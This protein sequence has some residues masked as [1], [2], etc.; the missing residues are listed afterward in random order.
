MKPSSAPDRF[1]LPFLLLPALLLGSLTPAAPAPAAAPAA[2]RPPNLVFIMADDLG[3]GDLPSYRPEAPHRT[4]HLDRLAAQGARFTDFYVTSPVCT[5]SRIAFLTGRHPARYRAFGVIWP[6]TPEG[7][8][9]ATPILSEWLRHHGYITGIVG[10]WHVG[11]LYPEQLPPARG[12]DSWYGMPYPNDMAP[13]HPQ[14]IQRK[15]TWPQMPMYRDFA[16]V[17]RPIDPNLLT[18]QYTYEALRFIAENHH[19]PFF[20]FLSH[21]MPHSILGASPDFYGRS[22]NGV[23]GDGVEELDW[24]V[25]QVLDALRAFSLEA[26]TLVFFTSDNGA[27]LKGNPFPESGRPWGLGSNLPLRGGKTEVFEGGIRLPAIASWPGVIPPGS[28]LSTPATIL[29]LIPTWADLASLPPMPTAVDGVSLAPILRQPAATLPERSLFFGSGMVNA[30]R[31][32]PWKFLRSPRPS[33][34]PDATEEP[35]LFNLANDPGETTNLTTSHPDILAALRAEADR[36]QAIADADF[37]SRA[38]AP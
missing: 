22:A 20:L 32:G 30:V 15:E 13:G 37:A 14:E 11:H 6:T 5:P 12:F 1:A 36:F 21:A 26:N 2:S 35:L 27:Y 31:R 38:P 33:Y 10:K 4:P 23:Y 18:R 28:T 9:P 25:G 34:R 8:D 29:D 17:E 19:R 24:S 7:L 3:Y 16:V